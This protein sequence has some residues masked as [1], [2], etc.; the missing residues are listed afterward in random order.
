MMH[1]IIKKVNKDKNFEEVEL[2]EK[3]RRFRL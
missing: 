1:R 3:N 2:V